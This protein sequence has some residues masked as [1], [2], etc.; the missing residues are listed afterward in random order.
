MSREIQKKKVVL[1]IRVFLILTLIGIVVIFYATS[2]KETWRALRHIDIRFF[3]LACGLIA[4]DLLSGAFRIH[5]FVSKILRKGSFSL[6]FKANL[7]N[8]FL[9]AATPFQTGGGF[10]QLYIL[11]RGGVPY[12]AG[13]SVSLLNLIATLTLLFIAG[14][15]ILSTF[16]GRFSENTALLVVIGISRFI[17]YFTLVLFLLFLCTPVLFGRLLSL[18][19]RKVG[20]LFRSHRVLLAKWSSAI[21]T[22]TQDCQAQIRY[23][24][25]EEKILLVWNYLVTIVL[26]FNKCLVAY[27]ILRGLGVSVR[28]D[29]VIMLQ[30]L[31]VFILYFAPTP[32]ASFIAETSTSALMSLLVPQHLL[33]VFTVLWR[34]FTT[35]FGVILGSAVLLRAISGTSGIAPEKV[36]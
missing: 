36:T 22:F 20:S 2:S 16:A 19:G 25:R 24:W 28:L 7:A 3:F 30:M 34:F 23:F 17:L 10:A 14:T 18:T 32:G 6:C 5:I 29:E 35:Y 13:L 11:H 33:I 27:V 21:M 1:G 8:T 15:L 31:V 12:A 4:V 26:Y 9:A